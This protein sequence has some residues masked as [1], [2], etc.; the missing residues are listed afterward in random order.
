MCD[1]Y[2]SARFELVADFRKELLGLRQLRWL[3]L[4]LAGKLVQRPDRKEEHESDDHKVKRDGEKI[5]PSQY[6]ALLFCLDKSASCHF[7][8]KR[9][10]IVRKINTACNCADQRHND[11]AN[12]GI[13]DPR[14]GGADDHTDSQVDNIAPQCKF[15]EFLK[16]RL[17]ASI[18][19]WPG[20]HPRFFLTKTRMSG[21]RPGMTGPS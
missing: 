2:S 18:S 10:K 3:F 5:S 8:G 20:G 19:S 14:E 11:V 13:H 15:F 1:G 6:S 4:F 17:V 21:T 9:Q 12:Q 7:R 16:H